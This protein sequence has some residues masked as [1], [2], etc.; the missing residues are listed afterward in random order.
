MKWETGRFPATDPFLFSLPSYAW[1]IEHEWLSYLVFYAVFR[2]AGFAGLVLFKTVLILI[3]VL[4]LFLLCRCQGALKLCA[5]SAAL[6]LAF[7]A[8][9]DR[10][11]ERASLFSD[12][13]LLVVLLLLYFNS[14][15]LSATLFIIPALFL[16]WVNL[17]PGF[18]L[19]LAVLWMFI[20]GSVIARWTGFYSKAS[21]RPPPS[22]LGSA[23]A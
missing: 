13:L 8:G 9:A 1:H 7:F 2:A 18:I 22:Q 20:A 23:A 17:H 15:R 19:G 16:L 14:R 6:L 12:A 4:L 5:I 11:L 10:L 3:P 21:V